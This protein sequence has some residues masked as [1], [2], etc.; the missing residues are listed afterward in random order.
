MPL[1][2]KAAVEAVNR[3]FRLGF[4]YTNAEVLLMDLRQSGELTDDLFAQSQPVDAQKVM[5]VIDESTEGGGGGL[6]VRRVCLRIQCG[7]CGGSL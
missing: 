4:K 2:I 3:L 7:Q 5:S 1:L 6:Y